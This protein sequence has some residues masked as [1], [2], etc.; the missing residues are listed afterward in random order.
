[1]CGSC[2]C[3]S[4]P[5]HPA[6]ISPRSVRIHYPWHPLAGIEVIVRR[7][8][9]AAGEPHL[10]VLLPDG[11]GA[12]VPEWMTDPARGQADLATA[13]RCSVAALLAVCDLL[14]AVQGSQRTAAQ[15]PPQPGESE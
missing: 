11:T 14:W 10:V 12:S 6:H 8:H 3:R 2:R 4:N 15:A 7:R 13:P 9:R 5:S 1:R